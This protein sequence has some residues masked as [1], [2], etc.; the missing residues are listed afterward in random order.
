MPFFRFWHILTPLN[1]VIA[2][3]AKKLFGVARRGVAWRGGVWRGAA[4]CGVAGL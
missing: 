3:I 1:G 2:E 4:G